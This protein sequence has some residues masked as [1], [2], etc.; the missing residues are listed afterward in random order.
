EESIKEEIK[1]IKKEIPD[2][3]KKLSL[4]L[5]KSLMYEKKYNYSLFKEIFI[6]NPLMNKFS[7]SLIWNLY[8]K[9]NLFLNTFRYNNDGSYSNCDDE[10]VTINDDSFISLASPIEMN[11]ETIN[12]WKKQLEDYELLQPIN[13]LSII[14]LDKNNLENEI[15]K[16][17]NIEIAYGT[18]KAFGDRYSMIPSYMDYGTVKEYNLKIN[19]GDA[20]DISIDAEDS[21]DY[22]DKVK[23]NI[24]FYNEN[25]SQVSDR[26]IYT[27]LVLMI[28]D[29]RLNN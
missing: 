23:I 13:Q 5:Y 15:N 2:I 3:I 6:D 11:E 19:N 21:I 18:F 20:F 14:K 26:F 17:Q 25:N 22:K 29:F 16:L 9:D 12:K 1:Y 8:D 28:W 4:K 27:L 7:S 10:E 24:K